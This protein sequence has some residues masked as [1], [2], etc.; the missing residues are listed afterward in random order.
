MHK[1]PMASVALSALLLM[2]CGSLAER[3]ESNEIV[4]AGSLS[5]SFLRVGDCFS[6]LTAEEEAGSHFASSVTAT[7]CYEL[8]KFELYALDDFPA[9]TDAPFPNKIV[10]EA[11]THNLCVEAFGAYVG[12][13]YALS[14]LHSRSLSPS[15]QSWENWSDRAIACFLY[16]KG[17]REI[18]GSLRGT[19][20]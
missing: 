6:G 9:G 1:V 13:P 15:E 4:Q 17:G 8:H 19:R 16:D 14:K 7:P 3:G 10:L 2:A 5:V 18:V 11:F 20:H 12:L